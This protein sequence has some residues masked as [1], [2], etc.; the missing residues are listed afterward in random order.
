MIIVNECLVIAYPESSP[1]PKKVSG[2]SFVLSCEEFIE[3]RGVAYTRVFGHQ[4]IRQI[5]MG[6][7]IASEEMTYLGINIMNGKT[8]SRLA[9]SRRGRNGVKSMINASQYWGSKAK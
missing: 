6:D 3:R 4:R 9:R 7:A 2:G 8:S 5:V 1:L